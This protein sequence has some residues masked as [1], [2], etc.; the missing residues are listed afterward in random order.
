M[1]AL[2]CTGLTTGYTKQRPCV[3]DV[4]LTVE[5]G[6][7]RCLLGPNGAGK[8]TLLL[9]LAGMLPRF[10][11]DV[12]VDGTSL[13]GGRPHDA[14]RAGMVLV[15]DDRALFRRLS[16]VQN[17]RLAVRERSAR[18][19]AVDQ[20]IEYFPSL[21]KRLKVDAGRL[22]GGEQQMLAIGR[23]I[24][25]RPRVLLIDELSMGLAPVIVGEILD[26]LQRLAADTGMAVVL[27]EQHVHLALDVANTAAVLV[28]GNVVIDDSASA[29]QADPA[30]I[31]RAYIGTEGTVAV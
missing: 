10:A 7:I 25:Q 20:V 23:A 4:N 17:L 19:A 29:L 2:Q 14:V 26:V 11:G 24:V 27:V 21:E 6:E 28:H 22:S 8:T 30:R 3:R 31:E 15:P 12:E 5:A 16:T 13:T 9:S 18:G 1:S